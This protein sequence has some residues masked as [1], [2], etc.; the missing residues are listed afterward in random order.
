MNPKIIFPV[1]GVPFAGLSIRTGSIFFV[2]SAVNNQHFIILI[3]R[4][5]NLRRHG[6]NAVVP[7]NGEAGR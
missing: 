6:L 2:F 7:V 3:T 5:F 4:E 1:R